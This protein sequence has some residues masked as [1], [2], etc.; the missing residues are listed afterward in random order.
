L[1]AETNESTPFI[2]Y[3]LLSVI[4]VPWL[5]LLTAQLPKIRA[6]NVF[7][8]YTLLSLFQFKNW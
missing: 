3:E 5:A 7:L 2:E 6:V 1:Y 8:M 4:T